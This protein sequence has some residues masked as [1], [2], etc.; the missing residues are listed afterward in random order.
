MS[1][2]QDFALP[3]SLTSLPQPLTALAPPPPP[4]G[5][6]TLTTLPSV[7]ITPVQQ[8]VTPLAP[9]PAHQNQVQIQQQNP[10]QVVDNLLKMLPTQPLP[11]SH[12]APDLL[13]TE[14]ENNLE[15]AAVGTDMSNWVKCE[16]C[17]FRA[18]KKDRLARHVR[19]VHYKEKP[20]GCTIC[21]A[22]FGRKDKMKRHMATVHS[23]ERPF[24]CDFCSHSSG[25]KDKIKEHIQSVHLKTRPPKP[26]KPK[27][28]GVSGVTAKKTKAPPIVNNDAGAP[29]APL[30]NDENR[31]VVLPSSTTIEPVPAN[32]LT[33]L[34][35]HPNLDLLSLPQH[36]LPPHQALAN[37]QNNHIQLFNGSTPLNL[38]GLMP[39]SLVPISPNSEFKALTTLS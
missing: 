5:V 19:S 1:L 3:L 34:N 39:V 36:P 29:E 24:K 2:P 38:N 35:S 28:T 31:A 4:S 7:T 25:R 8:T 37:H 23:R 18:P 17:E 13:K 21:D 26:K 10:Q 12:L 14:D 16:F 20:Y 22:S 30:L 11:Q 27:S 6:S 32:V 15:T 33:S 9:A